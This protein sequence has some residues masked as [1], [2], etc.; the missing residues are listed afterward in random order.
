M[1]ILLLIAAQTLP[2]Y[3]GAVPVIQPSARVCNA[4][5][6]DL[7]VYHAEAY[8]AIVRREVDYPN[9]TVEYRDSKVIRN[10]VEIAVRPYIERIRRITLS[11]SGAECRSLQHQGEEAINIVIRAA[12]GKQ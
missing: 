7:S 8:G 12:F 10:E 5:Y 11:G 4:A 6:N 9:G 2:N 3:Y 1:S